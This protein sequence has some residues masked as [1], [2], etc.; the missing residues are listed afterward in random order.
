[1]EIEDPHPVGAVHLHII[2]SAKQQLADSVGAVN[3]DGG[4]VRRSDNLHPQ[5]DRRQTSSLE[6]KEKEMAAG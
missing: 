3:L 5:R 4:L 6:E 2:R 1:M